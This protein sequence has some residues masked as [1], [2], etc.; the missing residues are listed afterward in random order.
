MTILLK[1]VCENYFIK[2]EFS[3][4]KEVFGWGN[5]EYNQLNLGEIQQINS[6]IHLK[7]VEKCGKIIDIATGGSVCMV[8]NGTF[9]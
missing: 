5:S 1:F 3:D 4:K 6:P 9:L 2:I 8:L 7:M